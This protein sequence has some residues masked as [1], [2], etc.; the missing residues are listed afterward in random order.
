MVVVAVLFSV[1]GSYAAEPP[2]F[3]VAL[4]PDTQNYSEKY[5]ETYKAQTR[6]IRDRAKA[7]NIKFAIHL[8][9]IVQTA[10]KE[11][12]WKVADAA[13]KTLDG[14]VP[15]SVVPGNHHLD[16]TVWKDKKGKKRTKVTRGTR[17]YTKYFPPSRFK[18]CPWYGGHMG[19]D[20]ANNYCTFEG[21]GMTFMVV[22]LEFGPRDEALAWA[23]KVVKAH[24]DH[25]V[26]VATHYHM[27]PN[28]R[29]KGK[30]AK[31]YGFK[32]NVGEN[33]WNKF[34]RK[35]ANI[36]MVVSGHVL[37]VNHQTAVNDAGGKVHEI[38]CDYQ[39]LP[40]GGN[41]WLQ[42]LRFVPAANKIHVEA[43]SPLLREH[44]KE[45]QHTYTLEYDMSATSLKKAG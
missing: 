20:N 9:D 13:H 36:F 7:D 33:L 27:R 43:Y 12:E 40:N 34:V 17:L 19:D 1:A 31:P 39:G 37:G 30:Q 42:T 16:K 28:G 23:S 29:A 22:S 8:G 2:S 6:W 24:P 15:Y 10:S 25:R 4:L 45:P 3:T 41:G 26:I 18:D 44:N 32:A 5:P 11:K 21:G 14:V 38:L 35:H